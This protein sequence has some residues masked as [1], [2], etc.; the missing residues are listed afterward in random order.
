M[1]D[2]STVDVRVHGVL[3]LVEVSSLVRSLQESLEYFRGKFPI[4]LKLIALPV[5]VRERERETLIYLIFYPEVEDEVPT[6]FSHK[7]LTTLF[8]VISTHLCL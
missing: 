4:I 6:F 8:L 7:R 1:S 5:R 2:D 3:K